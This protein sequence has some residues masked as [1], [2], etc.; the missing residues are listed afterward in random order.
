MPEKDRP[1]LPLGTA[2]TGRANFPDADRDGAHPTQT[3][4]DAQVSADLLAALRTMRGD[5]VGRLVAL[6]QVDRVV[7]HGLAGLLARV[8][9]AIAAVEAEGGGDG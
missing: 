1:A 9:G 8:Q 5:L 6:H 7:D 4:D 2:G 3:P